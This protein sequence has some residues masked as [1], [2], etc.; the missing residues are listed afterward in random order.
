MA[1]SVSSRPRAKDTRGRA[2]STITKPTNTKLLSK[3]D[4]RQ[5]NVLRTYHELRSVIVRGQLPPGSRISERVIAD[6]LGLS[7]TPVRSALYRL[8]QEGLV[9]SN[10]RERR[11][12]V[13]PLTLADGQEVYF[14]VGH[15]EGLAA[16]MAASLPVPQRKILVARLREI[17]RQLGIEARKRNDSA[18][19]FELDLEFH[20]SFVEEVAGPRLLTL[21]RAIKPQSERYSRLY[22]SVLLD[23][24]TSSVSEHQGIISAIHRGDP[25][26]AQL[27]TE[28]NWD[29]A[30]RRLVHL[31]ALN[32]ERGIWAS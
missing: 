8:E 5:D 21:H 29:N 1:P 9:A 17:N 32:G 31:I 15:L 22:I 2:A 28:M 13:A 27:A 26:A 14:I 25:A 7:R 19:I 30:A 4:E 16:R 12:F 18:R 11:L 3:R 23:E 10:R 20:R 6:R 24:L